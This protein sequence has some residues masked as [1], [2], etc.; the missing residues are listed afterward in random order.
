MSFVVGIRELTKLWELDHPDVPWSAQELKLEVHPEGNGLRFRCLFGDLADLPRVELILSDGTTVDPQQASTRHSL[1]EFEA[2]EDGSGLVISLDE[3]LSGLVKTL[4]LRQNPQAIRVCAA[5]VLQLVEIDNEWVVIYN[6][7]ERAESLARAI[8]A[9]LSKQKEPWSV[10]LQQFLGHILGGNMEA[11]AQSRRRL[12]GGVVG[13]RF[14]DWI[15]NRYRIE[16]NAHGAKRTFRYWS[17]PERQHYLGRALDVIDA[18]SDLTPDVCISGGAVLGYRRENKLIEHDDDLDIVVGVE[19]TNS[20][21][22]GPE[23]ERIAARLREAGFRVKGYFF[24]HLWVVIDEDSDQTLDVFVAMLEG[25]RASF[26]PSHRRAIPRQAL[27]PVGRGSL[28]GLQLPMPGDIDA[29]LEGVY[30]RTWRKP[31]KAFQHPW[32][33]REYADLDGPRR[34][35]AIRTRGEVA[36]EARRRQTAMA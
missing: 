22:L 17:T 1:M 18:L 24:A 14:V 7:A 10:R 4:V 27:Y 16:F 21:G 28:E 13:E 35:P 12:G 31:D 29:Y 34:H 8:L 3:S 2:M 32:D 26:Y 36:A 5:V 6:S 11:A 15:R 9:R 33:R 20:K 30:G 25:D 19:A 23:L